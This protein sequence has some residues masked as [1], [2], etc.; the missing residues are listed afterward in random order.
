MDNNFEK[1]IN[2][3]ISA[4]AEGKDALNEA[5][6]GAEKVSEVVSQSAG[7]NISDTSGTGFFDFSNISQKVG[8]LLFH[9]EKKEIKLPSVSV[10]RKEVRHSLEK[11][12][13]N[14]LKQAKKIQNMRHFSAAALEKV[15]QQIRHLRKI[16]SE[17]LTLATEKIERLYRQYVLKTT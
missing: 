15:I 11:E 13:K 14:L 16:L 4:Q 8:N 17:L 12:E 2:Q 10:Q 9:R 3:E 6:T 5:L 7:E 1:R